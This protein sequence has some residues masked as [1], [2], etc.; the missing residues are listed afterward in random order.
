MSAIKN[1]LSVKQQVKAFQAQVLSLL[2]EKPMTVKEIMEATGA[3]QGTVR[4]ALASLNEL[5]HR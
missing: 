1:K 3:T 2:T 5:T 4:S